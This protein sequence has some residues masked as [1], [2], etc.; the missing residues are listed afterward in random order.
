MSLSELSREDGEK[1]GTVRTLC[2]LLAVVIGIQLANYHRLALL[3]ARTIL[4]TTEDT[5]FGLLPYGVYFL[6]PSAVVFWAAGSFAMIRASQRR[7]SR[8]WRVAALIGV[9]ELALLVLSVAVYYRN[10]G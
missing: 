8:V 9:L 6:L 10:V 4:A 1:G 5:G 2:V 3:I 7:P